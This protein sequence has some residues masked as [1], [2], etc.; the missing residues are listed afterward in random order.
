MTKR[1]KPIFQNDMR[2]QFVLS[3]VLIAIIPLTVLSVSLYYYNIIPLLTTFIGF[4]RGTLDRQLV[5]EQVATTR[6]YAQRLNSFFRDLE[7]QISLLSGLADSEK[8]PLEDRQELIRFYLNQFEH[9]RWLGSVSGLQVGVSSPEMQALYEKALKGE[10]QLKSIG[11]HGMEVSS[12]IATRSG[13]TEFMIVVSMPA[14]YLEESRNL[15]LVALPSAAWVTR[16][17]T[18]DGS[19]YVVDD[20]G[21][22]I[23][24]SDIVGFP[25]ASNLN[26]L[27]IV[28]DFLEK[29]ITEKAFTYKGVDNLLHRGTLS[30]IELLNWGLV[31]QKKPANAVGI[32]IEM[33][34]AAKD[35]MNKMTLATILG[36]F[37]IGLLAGSIGALIAVRF[38]K[39]LNMIL[40]GLDRI[41][42]GDFSYR[43][44]EIGPTDLQ[45]LT[46]TLN[47]MI[48][49]IARHT[50]DLE[51]NAQ[52]MRKLFMGSVSSLVAAIDAK[53]PYTQG[54]SRRV[55]V[56]SV[57]IGKRMGLS[58]EQL[59][60][61]EISAL[62]HDIGKLGVNE[63]LLKKPG[64]LTSEERESLE[65][66]PVLGAE[67]MR[68]MPMFQ[69]M[70]PG[71][72]H[73]HERWDGSGYPLGLVGKDIP[74]YGRIV[75][76]ADTFDAM[77]SSRP[78]QETLTHEEARDLIIG[79]S[80]IRYDPVVV[81]AFIDDFP[82]IST[83]CNTISSVKGYTDGTRVS[84]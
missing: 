18:F 43:F 75:A 8:I 56:I 14:F 55:Q 21:F 49:A 83:I 44:K 71:M 48:D 81:Q 40:K 51:Q 38:T 12:P 34:D 29:G 31:L 22:L 24:K 59:D 73:H 19:I 45:H 69:N 79:W 70:L 6:K 74:I 39:P 16:S 64:I 33:E 42:K 1:S 77:T 27:P 30:S 62:M 84:K 11:D 9:I 26:Y 54:H 5:V 17:E 66:H 52:N 25:L 41:A 20:K 15:F 58:S 36:L 67:I 57:A 65:L 72:L 82:E 3:M 35:L 23:L 13:S 53:D 50:N 28:K 2:R 63:S 4:N 61:L 7:V 76:V 32:M 37:F 60:E 47:S 80:G 68:H 10:L 78:Y 46:R